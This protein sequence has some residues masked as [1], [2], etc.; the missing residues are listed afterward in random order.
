MLRQ[1]L[2]KA[3]S[4]IRQVDEQI[5]LKE[6]NITNLKAEIASQA[7]TVN[8]ELIELKLQTPELIQLPGGSNKGIHIVMSQDG[9]LNSGKYQLQR[10]LLPIIDELKLKWKQKIQILQV[11]KE[12]ID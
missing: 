1:Q 11:Q 6:K 4:D 5:R 8:Q 10:D 3:E 12:Q 7:N 2:N 9:K